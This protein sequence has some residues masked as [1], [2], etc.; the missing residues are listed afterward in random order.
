MLLSPSC[1]SYIAKQNVF[2]PFTFFSEAV[3]PEILAQQTAKGKRRAFRIGANGDSRERL[4]FY[5]LRRRLG[6]WRGPRM[7][8]NDQPH[9]ACPRMGVGCDAH[10]GR[11]TL[12]LSRGPGV[13]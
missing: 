3:A 12:N 6:C 9:C 4:C 8:I 11:R 7:V 13:V 2:I 5:V 10:R 1:V